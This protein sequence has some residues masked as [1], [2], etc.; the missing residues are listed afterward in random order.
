M[1]TGW[2]EIQGGSI[3]YKII[4]RGYPLALMHGGPGSDH[5]Y[6]LSLEHLAED[7]TL[8][9]YD[10]RC[11]GRSAGFSLQSMDWENLTKDAE[12]LRRHLGHERWAVLGHSFGGMT[13]LEYAMRYPQSLSHLILLDTGASSFWFRENAPLLLAERNFSAKAIGGARR[14]FCGELQAREV[15]WVKL[16]MFTAYYHGFNW[17]KRPFAGRGKGNVEALLYGFRVLLADW[18]FTSRLRCI[19]TPT[20]VAAGRDDFIFPPEHQASLAAKIPDARLHIIEK[21]GHN[22][23]NEQPEEVMKLVRA[24]MDGRLP[25]GEGAGP[26]RKP[27]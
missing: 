15:F 16:R 25:E 24:F 2:L 12:H 13:A 22:A 27:S 21:A 1:K 20:L 3:F 11:N 6:L 5:S 10:H 23:A 14:L 7:Y 9:F 8:I 4:G 26:G 17:M 19:R 18:D